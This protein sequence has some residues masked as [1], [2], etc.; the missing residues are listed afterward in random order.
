MHY[1][2]VERCLPRIEAIVDRFG[3]AAEVREL[4]LLTARELERV[5]R[6]APMRAASITALLERVDAF[7]QTA[8][9]RQLLLICAS[10][11]QA[12]PGN[13]GRA[14]GKALLLEQARTACLSVA[15]E[16][17]TDGREAD[18]AAATALHEARALAVAAALRSERWADA[19][20]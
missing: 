15:V 16:D 3:L 5:H 12:Y 13:T 14:Y 9:Y 19:A 18:P 11:F 6:A 2:H 20:A 8:R 17:V 10:D 4:A 1:K 7:G